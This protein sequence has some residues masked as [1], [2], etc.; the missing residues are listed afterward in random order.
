MFVIREERSIVGFFPLRC[1]AN[2]KSFKGRIGDANHRNQGLAK[3]MGNTI[4]DIIIS[5]NL[6][7]FT[8][9]SPEN[10]SSL[11]STMAV[12]D[13]KI[14]RTLKNGYHL[15]EC[16]PKKSDNPTSKKRGEYLTDYKYFIKL[17]RKEGHRHAA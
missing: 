5:L 15:L 2:R 17:R 8:T 16:T 12:N 4:N 11:A 13:M 7:L 10:Y 1:F 3:I 6:K 9:I 14:I